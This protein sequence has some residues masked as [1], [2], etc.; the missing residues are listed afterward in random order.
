MSR[1]EIIGYL[2]CLILRDRKEIRYAAAYTLRT[3][4]REQCS[5]EVIMKCPNIVEN[6]LKVVV[7]DFIGIV[8]LVLKTLE[9]LIEWDPVPALKSN[10]FQVVLSLFHHKDPKIT[11]AAMDCMTQLLNDDIGRELADIN[12]ITF[13]LRPFLLHE[14]IE[15][16]ISAAALMKAS[17]LTTRSKW[18]AKE[19]INDLAKILV[20]LCHCPNKPMLQLFCIQILINLCDCPD[21]RYHLKDHWEKRIKAIKVRTHEEWDGTTETTSFGYE[22][23]HHYRSLC[24]EKVETIKNEYGDSA[25]AVN[26]H[27]YQHSLR[28]Y[29]HRLLKAIN[30]KPYHDTM[31]YGHGKDKVSYGPL[32]PI[33]KESGSTTSLL[34]IY[35]TAL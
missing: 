1:P 30:W 7:N 15:V 6:L 17:T 28:D 9:N 8:I 25:Q 14:K 2:L 31:T 16:I 5:C 13:V 27:S 18:R 26:V 3:L 32:G 29:K 11:C 4:S 33:E 23:G 22:Y 12:D 20:K 19:C 24:I 21:V 34:T 35:S 10:A